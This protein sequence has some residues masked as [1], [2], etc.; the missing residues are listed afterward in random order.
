MI[1]KQTGSQGTNDQNGQIGAIPVC[2]GPGWGV[3]EPG[4]A[5]SVLTASSTGP[6][7]NGQ[8]YV[9][10]F[11]GQLTP[12][13]AYHGGFWPAATNL[14]GGFYWDFWVKPLVTTVSFNGYV[15]S[16]GYG[17]AH[18]LLVGFQQ[19][20]G[21]STL[22]IVSGNV[23]S[24][25][26]T[27][28]FQADDG[29][30]PGEWGHVAYIWD[31]T[32]GYL[33]IYI[34]GI[35]CMRTAFAGPR[36]SP[37]TIANG[38]N[39]LCIG[40]S[41]HANLTGCLACLRGFEGTRLLTFA[42]P[43][44]YAIMDCWP[45]SPFT[46]LQGSGT[47]TACNFLAD[48]TVPNRRLIP[49]LSPYG[50][51]DGSGSSRFHPGFLN[52]S[53]P[54]GGGG[55]GR[56]GDPSSYPVPIYVND[57]TFPFPVNGSPPIPPT[58]GVPAPAA[59]PQGAKVFDS[60]SRP[61][62]TWAFNNVGLGS[63]EGGSLGPLAYSTGSNYNGASATAFWGILHG[64]AVNCTPSGSTGYSTAWVNIGATDM[65][66]RVSRKTGS[67]G[68]GARTGLCARLVD[69]LNY[70]L[71]AAGN[72]SNTATAQTIY[73]YSCAAGTYTLQNSGGTAAPASN[74][75]VLRAVFS[76]TTLTVYC[77][78][79]QVLQLT[80]ISGPNGTNAGLAS[81]NA[82][83]NTGVSGLDR[84]QNFTVF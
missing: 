62:A 49:D 25:S 55:V 53:W 19:Q 52:G 79:T 75:V 69:N 81:F 7:W 43:G 9:L 37:A 48:Y 67:N 83:G 16:D 41:D 22:Q 38:G 8:N 23:Y 6:A 39:D 42:S 56:W 80:G 13:Q 76:G 28:S 65:D 78:A 77:D 5:G 34:D 2:I 59:A 57:S 12:M 24:G 15:I 61:N 18:A 66:V 51:V 31:S 74:W 82:N 68:V 17:G 26:V 70:W 40:G 36:Q 11:A 54:S 21:A 10:Q 60:F 47:W 46:Y 45:F 63:T 71:I 20:P 35:P 29:L 3:L 64:A 72:I 30:Y 73:V 84:W 50:Y 33:Y 58:A 44:E 27:T 1:I 32:N 4:P 14:T